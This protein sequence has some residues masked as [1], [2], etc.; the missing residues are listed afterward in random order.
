MPPELIF[1]LF[2]AHAYR[3]PPRFILEGGEKEG[4][5]SNANSTLGTIDIDI[6]PE[7]WLLVAARPKPRLYFPAKA[8]KMYFHCTAQHSTALHDSRIAAVAVSPAVSILRISFTILAVVE[9]PGD[10]R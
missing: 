4:V 3:S 5:W 2:G 1:I 7:S 8:N 6:V 9:T 10:R